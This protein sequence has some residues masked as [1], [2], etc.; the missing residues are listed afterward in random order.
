[1]DAVD[2]GEAFQ[3]KPEVRANAPL[4][5][6]FEPHPA[7]G[8]RVRDLRVLGQLALSEE[9]SD[10]GLVGDRDRRKRKREIELARLDV[11]SAAKAQTGRERRFDSRAR[12][13]AVRRRLASD[14]LS[15]RD[16][17]VVVAER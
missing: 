2:V 9:R 17:E 16:V 4:P 14:E 10:I 7:R 3:A 13:N 12:L 1:G 8:K 6:S 11:R 15:D 5:N